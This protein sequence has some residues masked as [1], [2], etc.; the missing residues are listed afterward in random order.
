[1]RGKD[2]D[3]QT[4]RALK[5]VRN[6]IDKVFKDSPF[7]GASDNGE[8]LKVIGEKISTALKEIVGNGII[9]EEDSIRCLTDD[10]VIM[11][12]IPYVCNIDYGKAYGLYLAGN[13]FG[14]IKYVDRYN[15][16]YTPVK[17]AEYI[18]LDFIVK[19]EDTKNSGV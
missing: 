10:P 17:S 19:A 1:M 13:F 8:A 15:A 7:L 3:V 5:H 4:E 9:I 16:V 14:K 2:T 18:K 12:M 11:K 6:E